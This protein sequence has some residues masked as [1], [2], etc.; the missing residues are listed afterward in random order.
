MSA[1]SA[2]IN[3]FPCVNCGA[4]TVFGPGTGSM[5][6]AHCGHAEPVEASS[7]PIVEN[8]YKATLAQAGTAG[9]VAPTSTA[10]KEIQCKNCGA[11]TMSSKQAERCAFCDSAM[12]VELP[13]EPMQLPQAVL[14]FEIKRDKAQELFVTWLSTRWFA[15]FKLVAR[16][17]REGL[18]GVYL[19]Y[20]TYDS[21]TVT[22]YRGERG[23]Y[24]YVTVSYTDSNGK[25]Q[26]K[27][28]RR[29]RW[30]NASGTV[31]VDFDD[32]LI[33][34]SKSLP[35]KLVIDLEPWDLER[36]AAFNPKYLAGF[37][38][39][40][41]AIELAEGFGLAQVRM[42]PR[43]NDAIRSDIGGDEQRIS[44]TDVDYR[45][46]TWKHILMPLWL[47]AFHY[48]EKVF[49]VT[50]NA[51][52]GE[53]TGERPYSAFKIIMFILMI[54]AIIGGIVYLIMRAKQP[55]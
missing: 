42:E 52:T 54:C 1:S 2:A 16:A 37:M 6:C 30:S 23:D 51:R 39:E 13:P 15:P 28:E 12:V 7:A 41:Q 46:I 14:P 44:S 33:C 27:Q 26:T 43:I 32:V 11:R 38:A 25:Q 36:L 18:D 3:Q 45:D 5:L 49:R 31:N 48:N 53:V 34:G 47:S 10:G 4:N 40:R 22:D 19:P 21:A 17:K 50:V 35:A 8:D 24:Y 20:W 9:P 29:T 55:Q